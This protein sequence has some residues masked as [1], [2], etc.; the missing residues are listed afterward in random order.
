MENLRFLQSY[1]KEK[2]THEVRA[3][4]PCC[5]VVNYYSSCLI[6]LLFNWPGATKS[7]PRATVA[8]LPEAEFMN[9][10]LPEAEFMNVQFRW[11]FWA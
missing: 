1:K 10:I 6:L 5:S 11:G 9:T 3:H 2:P 8:I 4:G 7:T